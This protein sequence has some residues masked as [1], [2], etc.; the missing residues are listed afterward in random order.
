MSKTDKFLN[1]NNAYERLV[2]EYNKHKVLV[3][4][5]DFDCT[6]HDYHNEGYS[7]QKCIELLKRLKKHGMKLICWTAYHDHEYVSTFL[8]EKGIDVD[9]INTDGVDLGYSSRK[10]FFN[11]LLD[12]RAGLYQVYCDLMKLC[13]YIEDSI[14][15]PDEYVKKFTADEFIAYKQGDSNEYLQPIYIY[16]RSNKVVYDQIVESLKNNVGDLKKIKVVVVKIESDDELLQIVAL[17]DIFG[18]SRYGDLIIFE[19]LS[20]TNLCVKDRFN[21]SVVVNQ[22]DEE[23]ENLKRLKTYGDFTIIENYDELISEIISNVNAYMY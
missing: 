12:D 5:F 8:K 10:P 21:L 11:A 17:D 1:S 6:V 7:Y 4:G 23:Y 16:P 18:N 3:F 2:K 14:V 20:F 19:N 15:N 22:T 9:G 13:D